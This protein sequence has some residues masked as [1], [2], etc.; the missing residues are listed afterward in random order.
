MEGSRDLFD[1]CCQPT[2]MPD[3]SNVEAF[4]CWHESSVCEPNL[5][6]AVLPG[7][8]EHEIG[9]DPLSLVLG[10]VEVVVED[11][12]ND[13]IVAVKFGLICIIVSLFLKE[14]RLRRPPSLRACP[15][16]QDAG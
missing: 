14:Q 11:T 12:P 15:A 13:E 10:E 8:F 5:G 2:L 4:V 6:L 16:S 9:A 1:T 3:D 7:E